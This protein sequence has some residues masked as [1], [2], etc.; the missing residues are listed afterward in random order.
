MRCRLLCVTSKSIF[1][2]NIAY[3]V[4]DMAV[5]DMAVYDMAVYDMAVYDMANEYAL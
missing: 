2:E 5:Y 3:I 4:Y 1:V